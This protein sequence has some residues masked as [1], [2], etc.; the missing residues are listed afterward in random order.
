MDFAVDVLLVKTTLFVD[1][2]DSDILIEV[3]FPDVWDDGVGVGVPDNLVVAEK[4]GT[5]FLKLILPV[6]TAK[7]TITT[8]S[9]KIKEMILFN[10]SIYPILYQ[11]IPKKQAS[12]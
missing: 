8:T 6:T 7:K 1:V 11:I 9:P 12:T 4:I 10:P 5:P 2:G 3:T